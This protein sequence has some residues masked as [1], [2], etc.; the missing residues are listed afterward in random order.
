MTEDEM[1]DDRVMKCKNCIFWHT[2]ELTKKKFCFRFP[3]PIE[4]KDSSWC[5]EWVHTVKNSQYTDVYDRVKK[6][7]P[8]A[9][10]YTLITRDESS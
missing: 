2:S 7:E 4:K 9:P 5:G 3:Q 1:N 6:Q 10:R 8:T